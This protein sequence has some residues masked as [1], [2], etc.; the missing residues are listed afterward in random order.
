MSPMQRAVTDAMFRAI[1]MECLHNACNEICMH[2]G[3]ASREVWRIQSEMMQ[4]FL[5]AIGDHGVLSKE[6]MHHLKSAIIAAIA[7]IEEV[8]GRAE[9]PSLMLL[10]SVLRDLFGI[11]EYRYPTDIQ[12]ALLDAAAAINR[13]T[14]P[15]ADAT[16]IVEKQ[17]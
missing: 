10:R 13:A 14:E 9:P 8:P 15:K 11:R 1:Y 7:D 2:T 4:K 6:E 16:V 3:A 5:G 12:K 17:S